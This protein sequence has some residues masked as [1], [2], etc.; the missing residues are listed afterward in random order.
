M[1]GITLSAMTA[2]HSN[3]AFNNICSTSGQVEAVSQDFVGIYRWYGVKFFPIVKIYLQCIWVRFF[4]ERIKAKMCIPKKVPRSIQG[5]HL[6]RPTSLAH[7]RN[8]RII[9]LVSANLSHNVVP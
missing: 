8:I 4:E 7:F 2:Y 3:R 1:E 6:R 9:T 5:L